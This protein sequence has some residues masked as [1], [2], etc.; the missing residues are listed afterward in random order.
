[1][2]ERDE[3][4]GTVPEPFSPFLASM[5]AASADWR[6][7]LRIRTGIRTAATTLASQDRHGRA[8]VGGGCALRRGV[9][10]PVLE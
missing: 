1:M 5:T 2:N 4:D 9:A 8:E 7:R 6:K 3:S 10:V